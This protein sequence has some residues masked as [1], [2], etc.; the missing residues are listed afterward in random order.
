[1]NQTDLQQV[2]SKPLFSGLDDAQ[3]GCIEPG[4][5][6]DVPAGTVLVSEGERLPFFFL[7]LEGE[8]RLS[9]TYDRQ[10]ILMGVIKPGNYTGEITL[11]LNIPWL[12]TAR[13]GR[14]ARLFRLGEE[15]FWRMMSTCRSVARE[16]FH[17]AANKMR[18]LE[19]YS[20]QREKLVS[21]A[22][23]AP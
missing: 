4:E 23:A 2:R 18:N 12:A 19:G 9:R 11:L 6:I 22:V 20:L 3:L 1:M 14:P 13:V 21:L 5:V 10:T 17:T 7:V 16:I 8:V 15:D